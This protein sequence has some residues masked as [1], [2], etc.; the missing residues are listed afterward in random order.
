MSGVVDVPVAVP[1][2]VRLERS[3]VMSGV[4]DAPV[5]VRSGEAREE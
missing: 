1:V 5:A 2:P 3:D 4:V